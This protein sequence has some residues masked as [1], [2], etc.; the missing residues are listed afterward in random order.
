MITV[1]RDNNDIS[2]YL[3]KNKDNLKLLKEE[4]KEII[5]ENGNKKIIL[6]KIYIKDS[7]YT[8]SSK[9]SQI[10]YKE[11]NLEK[12]KEYKKNYNKERYANDV[13]YREKLKQRV[14]ENKLRKKEMKENEK[15]E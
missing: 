6:T 2:T 14:K 1:Q 5:D 9:K 4:E 8:E 10:K 3:E 15:K 13:E 12:I 7:T 11:K